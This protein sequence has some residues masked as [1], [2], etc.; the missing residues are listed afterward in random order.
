[1][2][3]VRSAVKEPLEVHTHND[4]GLGVA[5]AIAGLKNGASS[6][7]T[8]VNGIGER[9]GNASFEEVAMALKYL[10]GQPVRFD[11][12]K[13][14]ELS[15]LVQRLTAFPLSPNKPVVGDRVFTR[16]AGIS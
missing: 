2:K 7:H 9:A 12:S 14:K 8:S 10:Y 16:E 15:E 6:V 1:V 4:F 5:T 11:F 13:F 3:I